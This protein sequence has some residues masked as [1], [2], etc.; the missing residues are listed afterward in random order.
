MAKSKYSPT[1]SIKPE[2]FFKPIDMPKSCAVL[3][4]HLTNL[5]VSSAVIGLDQCSVTSE[6]I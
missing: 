3:L 1:R 6:L 2:M 5:T 4:N